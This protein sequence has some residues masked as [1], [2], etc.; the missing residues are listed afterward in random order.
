MKK[1]LIFHG[2]W[3]GHEP[4]LVSARFA[5]ILGKHG[6]EVDVCEGVECLADKEKLMTYD[7][8]VPCVTMST[9]P[10]DYEKNI[11]EAIGSGVGIAG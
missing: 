2:G 6:F 4:K 7:L 8:L 5:A 9:L 1:A 10:R 3:D 11:S